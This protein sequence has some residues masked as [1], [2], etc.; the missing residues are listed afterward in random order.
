[1][2]RLAI[3]LLAVVLAGLAGCAARRSIDES[4]SAGTAPRTAT[5]PVPQESSTG[6]TASTPSTVQDGQMKPASLTS[7]QN[8]EASVTVTE[9]KLIRNAQMTLESGNP[10]ES[11]RRISSIAETHG[12]FVVNSESRQA[13]AEGQLKPEM[14]V[15]VTIRVPAARFD[16]VL[17]EIR[18][19]GSRVQQDKIT[20]QD[21]T[22]EYIDLEARIRAKQALEAQFM[23]IMKQARTVTDALE[24]QSQLSDVRAE[25]ERLEGRRRFLEN[26]TSLSTITITIMPPSQVVSSTGFFY[27]VKRAFADGLDVA[28]LITLGL[29]RLFIGLV[30]ILIFIVLPIY[31]LVR[32]LVRRARRRTP[33]AAAPPPPATAT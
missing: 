3:F 16:A 8:S 19:A 20:T 13:N 4:E 7:A 9:R 32:Y 5:A 30:P 17:A 22:E 6:N 14:T 11:Q 26:Q 29:I 28:A 25:I 12:G 15:T 31:L 18:G 27:S 33:I 24:V 10:G 1:M 21:V 23:E 2:R